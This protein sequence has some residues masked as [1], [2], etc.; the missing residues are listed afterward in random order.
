MGLVFWG[1]RVSAKKSNKP[2]ERKQQK[3]NRRTVVSKVY[4]KLWSKLDSTDNGSTEV[5]DD[6]VKL[7]KVEKDLTV[8][9]KSG[10]KPR[11]KW[12]NEK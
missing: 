12:E 3:Y 4:E 9:K 11:V 5:I 1:E 8:E 10:K 6:L 2:A 7:V